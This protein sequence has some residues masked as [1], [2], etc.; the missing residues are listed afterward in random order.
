MSERTLI[1]LKP[2]AVARQLVGRIISRFEDKGLQIVG[3]KF[4]RFSRDLA[5]RHYAIHQ[6][7][8]F[9]DGLL[10][11]ITSGPVL[12]LVLQAPGAI[13]LTRKLMGSTFGC[14]AEPGTL[15]GDFGASRGFNL[16]HG[17]DSPQAAAYE[18]ALY[19]R[20]DELIDY[21]LPGQH[22]LYGKG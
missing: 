19:F 17:S 1:I 13:A 3:A 8:P 15:R 18:I 5:A 16:V 22:W 10:D 14:E 21:A 7:K 4:L 2:D 12:V 20:D 6:G 9:Y 11:Y